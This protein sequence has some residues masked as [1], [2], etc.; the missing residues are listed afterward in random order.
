MLKKSTIRLEE[1]NPRL[2]SFV[3]ELA[4]IKVYLQTNIYCILLLLTFTTILFCSSEI[5][6]GYY[7]HERIHANMQRCARSEVASD[8]RGSTTFC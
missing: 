3:E 6:N 5:K 2:F 8:F 1:I 4:I 7:Y